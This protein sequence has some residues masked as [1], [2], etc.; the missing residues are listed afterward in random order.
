MPTLTQRMTLLEEKLDMLILL[1]TG[2]DEFNSAVDGNPTTPLS[3]RARL[4]E[5][6]FNALIDHLQLR[7]YNGIKYEKQSSVTPMGFSF[8]P[9]PETE[10]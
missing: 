2:G 8:S 4:I 3:E 10:E 6:R 5:E 1:T 7:E 9:T